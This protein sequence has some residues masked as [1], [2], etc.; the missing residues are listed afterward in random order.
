MKKI[1]RPDLLL[2]VFLLILYM[3]REWDNEQE[4]VGFYLLATLELFSY[5][6]FIL[7]L[8]VFVWFA[9]LQLIHI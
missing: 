5:L 2:Y 4:T 6:F 9:E 7:L 1:S 3:D 8:Y